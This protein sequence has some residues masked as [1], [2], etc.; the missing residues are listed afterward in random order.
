MAKK[1]YNTE[2]D[3]KPAQAIILEIAGKSQWVND[4]IRLGEILC[5]WEEIVGKELGENTKPVELKKN[6]LLVRVPDSV[7]L[8]EIVFYRD[9]IIEKIN[10]HFKTKVVEEIKFYI[11]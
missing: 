1:R 5:L 9:A 10:N 11:K 6:K 3:I 2:K 7:W 4:G 8:N